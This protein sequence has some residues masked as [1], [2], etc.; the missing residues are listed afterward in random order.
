[1]TAIHD[2]DALRKCC[3]SVPLFPLP[4]VVFLPHTL[5]PLHVFEP[6]YRAL[7]EDILQGDRVVAI[8]RL[9]SGWEEEY[10]ADPALV[11]ICGVG[12]VMR[13]QLLPDGRS[14]MIVLG[15]GRMRL[16][17]DR[18]GERGY[19]IGQGDL[20]DDVPYPGGELAL[21]RAHE[22]LK[23]LAAQVVG[24]HP[25]LSMPFESL[26]ASEGDPLEFMSKLAHLIFRDPDQRQ[27]FLEL[28]EVEARSDI[29]LTTLVEM[30]S[31][32]GDWGG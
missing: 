27:T 16:A 18:V 25:D 28:D 12:Q 26:M 5:L 14:N 7:V 30:Q 10:E 31:R 8:P 4:G 20:L 17:G 11:P 2:L 32:G 6:R 23:L 24:V 1:M 21:R 9:D 3:A 29:L 19:R 15:L 13:H 22:N